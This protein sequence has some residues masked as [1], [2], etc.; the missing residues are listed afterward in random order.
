MCILAGL[1]GPFFLAWLNGKAEIKS[2][3]Q[4]EMIENNLDM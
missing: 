2:P 3:A 1:T 4:T